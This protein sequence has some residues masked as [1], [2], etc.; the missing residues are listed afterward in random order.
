[1]GQSRSHLGRAADLHGPFP[2]PDLS[3]APPALKDCSCPSR[4]LR[5]MGVRVGYLIASLAI[6]S[7]VA[8]CAS[9]PYSEPRAAWRGEVE[10]ACLGSGEVRPTA[11]LQPMSTAVRRGS[12][13]PDHPFQVTASL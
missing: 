11:F 10:A 6:V 8:G 7:G 3:A 13:R 12:C 4:I 5:R 1:M 2:S 9:N